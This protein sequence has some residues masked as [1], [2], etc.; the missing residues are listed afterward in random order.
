[1]MTKSL[2]W[3]DLIGIVKRGN[4]DPPNRVERSEK[5]WRDLLSDDEFRI[6]VKAIIAE[7][8]FWKELAKTYQINSKIRDEVTNQMKWTKKEIANIK[9]NAENEIIKLYSRTRHSPF[10]ENHSCSLFVSSLT[11]L[12]ARYE[13]V[14]LRNNAMHG[15]IVTSPEMSQMGK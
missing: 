13:I 7:H 8:D 11:F 6:K 14:N 2:G 3:S 9:T 15:R 10:D 4:V 5:E 1:M 12:S